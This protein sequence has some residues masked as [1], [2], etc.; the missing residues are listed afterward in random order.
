MLTSRY[1][2]NNTALVLGILGDARNP[3][4]VLSEVDIDTRANLQAVEPATR[5]KR[6][7]APA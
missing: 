5:C 7:E 3:I 4:R 2:E 6:V 1:T